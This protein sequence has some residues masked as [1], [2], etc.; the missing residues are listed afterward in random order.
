M[1][2]ESQLRE[3]GVGGSDSVVQ[4]YATHAHLWSLHIGPERAVVGGPRGP[5]CPMATPSGDDPTPCNETSACHTSDGHSESLTSEAV[6]QA[7]AAPSTA[8]QQGQKLTSESQPGLEAV[9]GQS[10]STDGDDTCGVEGS[11]DG[12]T[13]K[14]KGKM[15]RRDTFSKEQEEGEGAEYEKHISHEK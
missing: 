4:Q 9:K 10:S 12:D 3:G 1:K 2:E 14:E 15:E 5:L 7:S 8:A 6:C 11:E 13:D